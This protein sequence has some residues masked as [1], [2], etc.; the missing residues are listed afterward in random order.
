LLFGVTNYLRLEHYVY[1]YNSIISE[2]AAEIKIR[3]YIHNSISMCDDITG[4]TQGNT[5]LYPLM[6]LSGNV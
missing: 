6:E 3:D 5:F 4:R 1:I 2:L